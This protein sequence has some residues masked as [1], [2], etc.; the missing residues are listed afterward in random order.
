LATC[1][2]EFN[3]VIGHALTISWTRD[4]FD[5]LIVANAALDQSLL[6]SKDRVIQANYEH[7]TW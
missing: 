4:P 6:L 1:G 2:K 7:A 3:S 5:R